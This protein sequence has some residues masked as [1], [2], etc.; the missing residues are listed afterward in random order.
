[1]EGIRSWFRKQGLVRPSQGRWLGGVCVGIAQRIGIPAI[2][3]RA[4]F[5]ISLLAPG[6]QFVVYLALWVLMP[7][8]A[9]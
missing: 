9:A 1:V 7:S 5:V 8:D 6:P 2:A 4:L 3:V